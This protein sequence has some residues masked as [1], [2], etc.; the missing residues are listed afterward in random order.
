MSETKPLTMSAEQE[1]NDRC[2]RGSFGHY[3]RSIRAYAEIDAL[4]AALAEAQRERDEAQREAAELEMDRSV[5]AYR[6]DKAELAA[7][8]LNARTLREAGEGLRRAVGNGHPHV[9][10]VA[11]CERFVAALSAPA[12]EAA[13][14]AY[15][16]RVAEAV[17]AQ[18]RDAT[19][20]MC[21]LE[22]SQGGYQSVA[23]LGSVNS[24]A[25]YQHCDGPHMRRGCAASAIRALDLHAIVKGVER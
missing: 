8:Q 11:A 4:R 24:P 2:N 14:D 18:A 20:W 10:W 5:E 7:A 16:L 1:A 15:A 3:A 23:Y 21:R 25:G 13:L 9:D 17:I 19:C 22:N 12:D 6:L